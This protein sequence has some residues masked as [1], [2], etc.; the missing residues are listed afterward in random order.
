MQKHIEYVLT[1]PCIKL[2]H[3]HVH[4]RAPMASISSG[5]QLQLVS[6]DFTFSPVK[7]V[8]SIFS[9]SWTISFNFPQTYPMK[10]ISG[11]TATEKFSKAL[12]PTLNATAARDCTL[13]NHSILLTRQPSR[14]TKPDTPSDFVH[15][16]GRRERLERTLGPHCACI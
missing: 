15:P 14:E 13:T 4:Q 5:A 8:M 2:K 3:Y 1:C 7:V 9:F 16:G 12:L 6:V 10:D 11:K